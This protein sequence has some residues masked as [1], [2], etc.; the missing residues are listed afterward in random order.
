M[1]AATQTT[2][3]LL[4][5]L[6][7]G[8]G[9]TP[10]ALGSLGGASQL[11][12]NE[13]K[14][15]ASPFMSALQNSVQKL[16]GEGSAGVEG[17][18]PQALKGVI[19]QLLAGQAASDGPP[20]PPLQGQGL[21]AQGQALDMEAL[22]AELAATPMPVQVETGPVPLQSA[23]AGANDTLAAV[24]RQIRLAAGRSGANLDPVPVSRD[25]DAL[26]NAAMSGDPAA[27]MGG[28]LLAE[29]LVA[30]AT[31]HP[32][33]PS[34]QPAH[35]SAQPTLLQS[36]SEQAGVSTEQ[37][38]EASQRQAAS[39]SIQFSPALMERAMMS[40][41]RG[42]HSAADMLKW[43]DAGLDSVASLQGMH[44]GRAASPPVVPDARP[45][46]MFIQTPLS[47]PQWQSDFSS[48]V[49]M[50]AK[51]G[52]TGQAQVA[53]IRLNPA[54]LGPV[55]VRVVMND[56]HASV[57]FTAQHG[58]VRDALETSLPRL[59]EMFANSGLQLA[60]ATVSDQSLQQ[61]RQRNGHQATS[62][63]AGRDLATGL[64]MD[65][66]ESALSMVHLNE[67][68]LDRRLDLYA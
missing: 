20:M 17:V 52:A 46:Q 29:R 68:G 15:G 65:D 10:G 23:P 39:T 47:D 58:A 54:Q 41:E 1:Q 6:L 11:F 13:A 5:A 35:K 32:M 66:D 45:G 37:S 34:A 2:S 44:T 53:E 4:T 18:D 26:P 36:L 61:R 3:S 50:L 22:L 57:T 62:G 51:G 67:M 7:Q 55:E 48:R 19:E 49:V 9:A 43:S 56:D 40:M 16:L 24:L 27:E 21:A 33:S 31:A 14:S 28:R 63:Q 25:P 8:Q 60:D 42:Q 12:G 64:S 38:L 30:L 59:R